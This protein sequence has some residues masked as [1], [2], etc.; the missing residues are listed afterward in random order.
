LTGTNFSSLLTEA[1]KVGGAR[2]PKNLGGPQEYI[3]RRRWFEAPHGLH[4]VMRYEALNYVDGSR[5][6]LDIYR[7]VRSECLSAGEWYYG[8]VTPTDVD[9]LFRAADAAHVVEIVPR[10]P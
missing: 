4:Q 7:L 6:I 3:R 2:I 9:A 1:E 5:S 8:T 10:R